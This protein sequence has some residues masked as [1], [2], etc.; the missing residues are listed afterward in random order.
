VDPVAARDQPAE[1]V[2]SR[3]VDWL[4][5][6]LLGMNIMSTGL[7]GIG[8]GNGADGAGTNTLFFAAGINEENDGLFGT[9]NLPSAQHN[10]MEDDQHDG[11][12]D[13]G[14]QMDDSMHNAPTGPDDNDI[15]SDGDIAKSSPDDV[16][17]QSGGLTL[18]VVSSSHGGSNDSLRV[19]SV[20]NSRI[21]GR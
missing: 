21:H 20:T 11:D 18:N 7:W 9:V 12:H 6:G 8:F 2:G 15:L 1:V 16:G 19:S 17:D 3:Y 10:R 4:V 5:P 14:P 13:H